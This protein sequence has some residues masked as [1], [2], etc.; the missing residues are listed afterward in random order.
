[1]F[2]EDVM[3]DNP[4]PGYDKVARLCDLLVAIVLG[5][6]SQ[7][8]P[9]STRT[10]PKKLDYAL[11]VTSEERKDIVEAWR[12]VEEHDREPRI[13][14]QKYASRW[15]HALYKRARGDPE[16]AATTQKVKLGMR[17]APA[18]HVDTRNRIMYTV[19]KLLW[20]HAGYTPG[21]CSS[22]TKNL[23]V[24]QYMHL[25]HLCLVDD[26][27]L[28]NLGLPLP[29]IN[30]KIMA[31]FILRQESLANYNATKQP[32]ALQRKE[33]LSQVE[34]APAPELPDTLPILD[35][36][37]LTYNHIESTAGLR[38]VKERVEKVSPRK[39]RRQRSSSAKPSAALGAPPRQ[40][41]DAQVDYTEDHVL[42]LS[43][44]RHVHQ[45]DTQ[46]LPLPAQSAQPAQPV[47]Q[48]PTS[49]HYMLPPART[50]MPTAMPD[51]SLGTSPCMY[52]STYAWPQPV[53]F[54]LSVL[55]PAA[56]QPA[57]P[58][59][60]AQANHQPALVGSQPY[61]M[62]APAPAISGNLVPA[63]PTFGAPVWHPS[64]SQPSASASSV[65]CARS[66]KYRHLRLEREEPRH[67]IRAQRRPHCSLCGEIRQ[68]EGHKRHR[69][70]WYCEQTKRTP[71]A[72]LKNEVFASFEEFTA[73]VDAL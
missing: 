48:A 42:P 59:H 70:R 14:K 60:A 26:V 4:L 17:F 55:Q 43:H 53:A 28:R 52:P 3:S 30:N 34:L 73:R 56:S 1:M 23:V 37:E 32:K 61:Q 66:T 18:A 12:E 40:Q 27:Q 13:F 36:P 9:K 68:G 69:S 16:Q 63:A 19:I 21:N 67:K 51:I 64:G 38:K 7:M 8:P 71:C 46:P 47:L 44:P 57:V 50:V 25:Q 10:P 31:Q 72:V 54:Q 6:P 45:V 65:Q 39:R 2:Q 49:Q 29:K 15:G 22:P 11:T 24:T 5:R 41:H 58:Q 33:H 20:L 62:I 35:R